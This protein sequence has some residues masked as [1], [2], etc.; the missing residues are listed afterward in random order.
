MTSMK[1]SNENLSEASNLTLQTRRGIYLRNETD[2]RLRCKIVDGVWPSIV[3]ED[4]KAKT[5]DWAE[6]NKG[7]NLQLQQSD[8]S[9]ESPT[10]LNGSHSEHSKTDFDA[11]ETADVT[12]LGDSFQKMSM[13]SSRQVIVND[14]QERQLL[15]QIAATERQ[16]QKR[17]KELE[18]RLDDAW[19]QYEQQIK[20]KPITDRH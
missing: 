1:A 14:S 15:Q 10:S 2:A 7:E 16:A 8:S 3:P 5:P 11:T 13:D 18:Y 9:D 17:E 6:P 4:I 20:Q 19:A 12:N